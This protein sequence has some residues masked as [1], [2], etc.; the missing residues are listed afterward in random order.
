MVLIWWFYELQFPWEH[1]N[2]LG[3]CRLLLLLGSLILCHQRH[4]LEVCPAAGPEPRD[5][6]AVIAEGV[7]V[8][9]E[10]RVNN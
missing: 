9:G 5:N 2:L 7:R 10:T 6:A 1:N 3:L 8:L 4:R